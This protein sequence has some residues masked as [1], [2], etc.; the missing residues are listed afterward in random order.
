GAHPFTIASADR[1]DRTVTFAI[2]ALGDYTRG[3]AHR[4]RAGQP[5]QVEGPYGRFDFTRGDRHAQQIWI[6]GGIGITPFLAWLE[7]LRDHPE[8][9]VSAELHYCIRDREA[10]PFVS[11][12]EALCAA[13]PNVRLY[14]H[15]L[16][17]GGELSAEVLA[18]H[19]DATRAEIWF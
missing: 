12:L 3:L 18:A 15:A 9:A 4:L 10:D 7:S 2:K 14:V 8:Q 11:R 1:G 6:A 5:V 19:T 17:Q 13:V 16:R